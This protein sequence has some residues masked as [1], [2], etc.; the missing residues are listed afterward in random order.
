MKQPRRSAVGPIACAGAEA[1]EGRL[2]LSVSLVKDIN[3]GTADLLP[4]L[5]GAI[6]QTV[7]FG[8]GFGS[9]GSGSNAFYQT[10]GTE[11]GT[12]EITPPWAGNTAPLAIVAAGV[13]KTFVP[14]GNQLWVT[15]G[16]MA[17][18]QLVRQFTALNQ[19]PYNFSAVN[20]KLF[21]L[22]RGET[23][24]FASD[25]LWVSDGTAAGTVQLTTQSSAVHSLVPVGSRIFFL[26]STSS[27]STV[28]QLWVSDGTAAG[29]LPVTN[30]SAGI[31]GFVPLGNQ[32]IFAT[33]GSWHRYSSVTGL[34]G[35]PRR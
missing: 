35:A 13:G 9:S 24:P 11:A 15:A 28:N 34:R 19:V 30:Q 16:S 4:R 5:F 8:P 26:A 2:L 20:G 33:A 23:S 6:G 25:Q 18:A 32:L 3:T 21:F 14:V 27:T 31:A 22:A 7:Y 1:L 17:D 10:D 29:T 12:Q